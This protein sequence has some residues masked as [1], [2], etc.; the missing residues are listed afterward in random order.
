[1]APQ[2][3]HWRRLERIG[4]RSIFKIWGKGF[5]RHANKSRNARQKR[6]V[7]LKENEKTKGKLEKTLA[8]LKK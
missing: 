6:R 5:L 7:R 8:T 4:W 2:A 3:V 1:M